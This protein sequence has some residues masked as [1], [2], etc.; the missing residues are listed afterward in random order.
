[1]PTAHEQSLASKFHAAKSTFDSR[2]TEGTFDWLR[3]FAPGHLV[4]MDLAE[5]QLDSTWIDARRD[6][7]SVPQFDAA[8]ERWRSAHVAAVDEYHSKNIGVTR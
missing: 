6:P 2:W 8:L 3:Q 7:G 4:V 5:K 1:M